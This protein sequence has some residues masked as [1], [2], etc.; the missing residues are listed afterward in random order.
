MNAIQAMPQGGDINVRTRLASIDFINRDEGRREVDLLRAGDEVAIVEI[1]DHGP[2]VAP[3]HL[4]RIFEPF[5]TTKPTGVG[6]GLGLSVSKNIV[7][8]H[9]GRLQVQN[10][11]PPGLRVRI[12]LKTGHD[13]PSAGPGSVSDSA[14]GA[15][16]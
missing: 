3:D 8:L 15:T 13:S 4:K 9:R 14:E 6:C 2:G 11:H 16:Q 7:E 1:R 10:V 12:F 5:F